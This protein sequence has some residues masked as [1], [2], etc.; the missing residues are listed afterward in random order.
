MIITRLQG[1]MKI[2]TDHI[3]ELSDEIESLKARIVQLQ[4]EATDNR[5]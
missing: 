3:G 5:N 4:K 2:K 1:D